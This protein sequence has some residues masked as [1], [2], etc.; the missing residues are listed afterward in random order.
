MTELNGLIRLQKQHIEPAT[1]VLSRAFWEDPYL[2]QAVPNHEKR[3]KFTRIA[4]L[5][6]LLHGIKHGEAYTVSEDM[7]GVA[8]WLPSSAPTMTLGTLLYGSAMALRYRAGLSFL[9]QI[10]RDD[11]Y[12]SRSRKLRAPFPHWYLAMLGVDP[13]FQRQGYASRLLRPMLARLDKEKIPCYL[14]TDI[15][16][17]VPLYQHFGFDVIDEGQLPS[18]NN[19]V[20]MML[21]DNRG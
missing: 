6:T 3:A 10:K 5:I 17:Y 9:W 16:E 1:A 12:A 18:S 13:R 7:E 14:E 4:F 8:L 20:W 11:R 19:K 15:P 21:R 2:V